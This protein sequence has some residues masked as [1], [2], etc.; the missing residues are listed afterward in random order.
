VN[1]PALLADLTVVVHLAYFLFVVAGFPLIWL[2]AWRRWGWV[3]DLRFRVGHLAAIAL[4]ALETVIGADCPL[5]VIEVRLRIQ[6]GQ[7]PGQE[8]FVAR[9]VD[10]VLFH[11]WPDWVFNLLHLGFALVILA[12]MLLIP[13]R[14]SRR[15]PMGLDSPGHAE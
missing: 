9:L 4:V 7:S 1:W 6:A 11:D 3:R 12:T 10:S 15:P 5:T 14:L 2:G 13:P 8:P